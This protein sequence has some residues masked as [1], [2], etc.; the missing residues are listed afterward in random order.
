MSVVQIKMKDASTMMVIRRKYSK[1]LSKACCPTVIPAISKKLV[2][3]VVKRLTMNRSVPMTRMM[4]SAFRTDLNGI[5]ARRRTKIRNASII[6][7][8]ALLCN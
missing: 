2:D 7:R 6:A 8:A 4:G 5:L 3:G 1:P